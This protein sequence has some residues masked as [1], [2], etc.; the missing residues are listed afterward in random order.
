[1]SFLYVYLTSLISLS[2]FRLSPKLKLNLG[3][4][5]AGFNDNVDVTGEWLHRSPNHKKRSKAEFDRVVSLEDRNSLQTSFQEK[6]SYSRGGLSERIA[7][8]A[9]FNVPRLKTENI[10]RPPCL[11]ISSPGLSPATL[12]ESPIFLSNPLVTF[13]FQ[14][15]IIVFS[16]ADPF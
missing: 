10:L 15:F 13:S 8:R 14:H 1:M 7:A 16:F 11:T 3:F 12:L 4:V 6:P 9:G 2:H 5:M